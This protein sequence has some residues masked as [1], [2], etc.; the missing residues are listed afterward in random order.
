[1]QHPVSMRLLV[2]CSACKRQYDATKLQAG[3]FFRC[4]CGELIEVPQPEAHDAAV[5]RCS[6]C[7]G[8]RQEGAPMCGFCGADFTLHERDL[9]T[10]CPQCMTRVG[11]KARY[12][13]HCA[14]PLLP[15]AEAG[16]PTE[17]PCP[18]CGNGASLN[19][20]SIEPARIAVLECPACAGLW[21]GTG[22]F[23]LLKERTRAR[24]V[25][26]DGENQ[27]RGKAKQRSTQRQQKGPLY[28]PCPI[29]RKLMNR[30]NYGRR[31]GVIVDS[32]GAH[33]LWFDPSELDA[34][35]TWIRN[36]GEA[37]A[38]RRQMEEEAEEKRQAALKRLVEPPESDITR[39]SHRGGAFFDLLTWL[40]GRV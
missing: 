9:D 5:V 3:S 4:L 8:P 27:A 11:N 1:M 16:K 20:R 10:I 38:Y 32:C 25:P 21:I 35:L 15:A 24:S 26:L 7:G 13:H 12:C 39:S 14:S 18:S 33:G 29:C 31:S 40:V 19:S 28:R 34:V 36:G 17:Y 22:E 30:R 2:A 23:S 6:S 37:V